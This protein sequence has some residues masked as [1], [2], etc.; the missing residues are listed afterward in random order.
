M[1]TQKR[2]GIHRESGP[3]GSGPGSGFPVMPLRQDVQSLCHSTEP[4]PVC[5]RAFQTK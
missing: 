4:C 2:M 3:F 1:E 5:A